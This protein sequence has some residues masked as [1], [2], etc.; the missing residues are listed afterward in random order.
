MR[1]N[2]FI[3]AAKL[4]IPCYS[5]LYTNFGLMDSVRQHKVGNEIQKVLSDVF[6][7]YGLEYHGKAFVTITE[8]RVSPDLLMAKVFLSIYNVKEPKLV[9]EK[10]KMNGTRIR[11]RMGK[12]LKHMRRIPEL[13]FYLD[14]SLD[15]VFHL[16]GLLKDL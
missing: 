11:G 3:L 10:V 9:L 14:D 8:V 2:P 6:Q 13:E 4:S 15:K 12:G 7:K 5:D 16:E 1:I